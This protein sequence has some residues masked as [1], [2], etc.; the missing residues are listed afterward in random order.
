MNDRINTTLKF[1]GQAFTHQCGI[2]PHQ[3]VVKPE[4]VIFADDVVCGHGATCGELDEDSLFY[5]MSRGITRPDAET[6]LVKAF[7]EELFD[8][9]ENAELHEALAAVADDW[10]M[11][12]EG[13]A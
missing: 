4:L 11:Q 7:L 5:L 3:H 1:Q 13:A 8:P 2:K 10:L 6:I 9:I 12:G